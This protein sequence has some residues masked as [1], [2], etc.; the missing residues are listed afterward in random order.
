MG[1]KIESYDGDFGKKVGLIFVENST[2]KS[3]ATSFR[4][5][6][7]PSINGESYYS[8][9]FDWLNHKP[10]FTLTKQD[11]MDLRLCIDSLID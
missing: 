8:L 11:L 1:I 3:K 6:E 2:R 9:C 10:T 5:I 7:N 4:I